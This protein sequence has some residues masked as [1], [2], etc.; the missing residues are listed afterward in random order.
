MARLS[1]QQIAMYAQSAGMSN[2]VLMS[3]IAMAESSGNTRAHNPLGLDNSYGLWQINML[4]DMG[5]ARRRQFG[6]SRNEELFDPAVNARAAKKILDGQGLKAWSTYTNGAYKRYM[7]NTSGG[8]S[9]ANWWD[10]FKD[11]FG[12][13]FDMGPGPEDLFDGGTENDPGLS[14]IPGAKE[15]GDIAKGVG[16]IAEAVMKAAQWMAQPKNWVRIAYVVGGGVLVG[17]GLVIVAKPVLGATPGGQALKKVASGGGGRT[18]K[19]K[20]APAKAPA[21]KESS[22]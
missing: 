13:G 6:I 4:G 5:P 18:P 17:A 22:T 2:P 16:T 3:A 1:Q 9:Q 7:P 20:K 15:I 21:K 10:D 12:D 14:D 8:A 19:A 11:G